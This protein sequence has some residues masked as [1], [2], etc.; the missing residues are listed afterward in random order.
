MERQLAYM[1]LRIDDLLDV[2]R[3]SCNKMELRRDRVLLDDVINAAVETAWPVIDAE[4]HVLIVE[5]PQRPV[6]MDADLTRIARV[7]SNLLT[8][9]ARYTAGGG[10]VWLAAPFRSGGPRA[11]RRHR[12]SARRLADRVR[13][14]QPG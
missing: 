3:I 1:V 9:S 2:S 4:S 10:R 14:I 5:L 11:R 8:N 6:Y 13:H 7:F 12:H